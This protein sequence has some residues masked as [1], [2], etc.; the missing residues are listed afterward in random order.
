M[1]EGGEIC[2][3]R[4]FCLCVHMLKKIYVLSDRFNSFFSD[5]HAFQH[6]PDPEI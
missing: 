2:C 5:L 4:V 1:R 3:C 6:C